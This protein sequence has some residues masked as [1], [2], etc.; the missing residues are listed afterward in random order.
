MRWY[1]TTV[2]SDI[3]MVPFW[4]PKARLSEKSEWEWVRFLPKW[5]RKFNWSSAW[6][7]VSYSA[8]SSVNVFGTS[9]VQQSSIAIIRPESRFLPIPHLH[10]TPSLGGFPS[11]YRHPVWCGKTR[12]VWIPDG[13]KNSKIGLFILT[14]STNVTDGRT[15]RRT[16]TAWRIY[17]RAYA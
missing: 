15:D 4:I 3:R 2:S 5:V 16:D 14:W 8:S 12:M 6:P 11:E 10:S 13:E 1:W 9:H 17:S 7:T